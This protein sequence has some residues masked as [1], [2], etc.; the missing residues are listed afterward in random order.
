VLNDRNS[1]KLLNIK[2][3]LKNKLKK[4][5]KKNKNY[6]NNNNNNNNNYNNTNNDD[7]NDNNNNNNNINKKNLKLNNQIININNNNNNNNNSKTNYL[8]YYSF[9]LYKKTIQPYINNFLYHFEKK[10]KLIYGKK[11]T[12]NF[13][14]PENTNQ[15]KISI[16]KHK[17]DI[18]FLSIWDTSNLTSNLT[19]ELKLKEIMVLSK[20]FENLNMDIDYIQFLIEKFC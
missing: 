20:D 4:K 1:L 10:F 14:S 7:V 19:N 18:I 13:Y 6:N 5:Y 11:Y 8:N 3:E 15:Y 12:T 17:N 16:N 2:N 9:Y